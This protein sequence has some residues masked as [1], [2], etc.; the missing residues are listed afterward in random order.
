MMPDRGLV[1]P[2][3]AA[4]L[5]GLLLLGCAQVTPTRFY[6]LSS[7]L[8][9]PGEA[10]AGPAANLTVGISAIA[11]PEY[12]NRPQL[13]TRDGSNRV[14]LS[15]FDNWIEPLQGMFA[16]T[17]AENLALLLGTDDVLTL[18]QRRPFR[19]DYQVEIEVMRFDTDA[20]GR[21]VLDARWWL[22]GPRGERVLHRARTTLVEDVP[23]TDRAAAARALSQAL[24][25]LSRE[26]AAA[27]AAASQG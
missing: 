23:G 3:A 20:E 18:P 25:A 10:A 7:V 5:L 14:V 8:A 12:L 17:L 13:V 6:T 26:I 16:R 21:A 2:L 1:G 9:P 4:G 11:L 19:P 27:I 24:G 15:D 22:L